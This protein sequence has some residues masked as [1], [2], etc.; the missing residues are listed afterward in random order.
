MLKNTKEPELVI[1]S[2]WQDA[3][4]KKKPFWRAVQCAQCCKE[5]RQWSADQ[6]HWNDDIDVTDDAIELCVCWEKWLEDNPQPISQERRE[7][8]QKLFFAKK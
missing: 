8:L 1:I 6:E 7:Y 5:W 3:N 4:N 2:C